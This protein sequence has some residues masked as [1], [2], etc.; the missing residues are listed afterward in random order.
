LD[1]QTTKSVKVKTEQSINHIE[2]QDQF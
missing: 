1:K 2:N